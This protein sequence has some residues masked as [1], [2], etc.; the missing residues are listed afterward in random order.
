MSE[1][2]DSLEFPLNFDLVPAGARGAE[3]DGHGVGDH[4]DMFLSLLLV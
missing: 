4:T 3:V 2:F 1:F